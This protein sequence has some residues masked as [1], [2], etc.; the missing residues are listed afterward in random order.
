[1]EIKQW[2]IVYNRCICMLPERNRA[3]SLRKS[4]T[5]VK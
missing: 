1:M 5:I 2:T 4:N 3:F